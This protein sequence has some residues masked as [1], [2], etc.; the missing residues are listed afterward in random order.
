MFKK[1]LMLALIAAPLQL[2]AQK[3][4]HF[5]YATLIQALPE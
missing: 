2:C 5:A 3:F 4:A 1:I